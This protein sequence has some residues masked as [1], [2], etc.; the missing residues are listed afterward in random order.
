MI[1]PAQPVSQPPSRRFVVDPKIFTTW[2]FIVSSIMIFAG[3]TS[4]YILA[5]ADANW[6]PLQVPAAMIVSTVLIVLSSGSMHWAWLSAK[7]NNLVQLRLGLAL[8]FVI[9]CA[10]LAS[11]VAAYQRLN[12]HG[13]YLVSADK[14][15]PYLFVISGLHAAHIISGLLYLLVV[16]FAAMRYRVHSKSMVSIT[17]LATFWHFIDVLWLY[18]FVFFTLNS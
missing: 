15:A 11:Q 10:F 13:F 7:R 3:L 8:T 14:N 5:S 12:A 2:L 1:M 6:R 17:Q 9:G 16:L 18:L 4:A